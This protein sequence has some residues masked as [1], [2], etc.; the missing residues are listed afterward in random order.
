MN[1]KTQNDEAGPEDEAG[2]EEDAGLEGKASPEDEAGLEKDADLEEKAGPEDE[3]GLEEDAGLEEKAG[4]EDEA[5]L[6]EGAGLEGKAGPE[7]EAVVGEDAG[8]QDETGPED[9]PG[10]PESPAVRGTVKWFNAEKGFGFIVPDDGSADIF[11]HLSALREAG[12]NGV[13]SGATIVCEVSGGPKGLQVTRV[14]EVDDS[15]A[16]PSP[17]RRPRSPLGYDRPRHEPLGEVGEFVAATVKWFNPNKGYGF[18][19][20]NEELPD[21]FVHM[22]TL[23]RCGIATL[24]R[25]QEVRVRVGQSGKGPQV[26]D[27]E[28]V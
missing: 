18:I 5:G 20:V 13:E 27:I 21:V 24:E 7:D 2:L 3:A 12:R 9:A 19:T 17:R 14:I 1:E 10:R 25:G 6:E 23:R 28:E 11:M 22:Q 4:P 8:L 26:A 15:T 16:D